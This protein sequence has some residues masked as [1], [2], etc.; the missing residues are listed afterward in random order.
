MDPETSKEDTHDYNRQNDETISS[1][2]LRISS[3]LGERQARVLPRENMALSH[4]SL[5]LQP[6]A[7]EG[8]FL[9]C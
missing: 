5:S 6:E 9:L 1:G 8:Q 7:A 4:L 3:S 2:M